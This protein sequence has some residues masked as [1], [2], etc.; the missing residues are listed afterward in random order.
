MLQKYKN[1]NLLCEIILKMS[2]WFNLKLF[3]STLIKE[4]R[5]EDLLPKLQLPTIARS[6]KRLFLRLEHP[7]CERRFDLSSSAKL[8]KSAWRAGWNNQTN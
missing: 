2:Y 5:K 4:M 6:E 7:F 8:A 3:V 1:Y